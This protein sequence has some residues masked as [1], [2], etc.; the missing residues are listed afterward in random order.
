MQIT[1]DYQDW[2]GPPYERKTEIQLLAAQS[3]LPTA[4]ASYNFTIIELSCD[5]RFK[6]IQNQRSLL[7]F[8]MHITSRDVFNFQVNNFTPD[9][10]KT[11]LKNT[12]KIDGPAT[13]EK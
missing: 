9:G 4:F 3:Y 10:C 11:H 1:L 5:V 2:R 13:K 12:V 7:V 6:E 8:N